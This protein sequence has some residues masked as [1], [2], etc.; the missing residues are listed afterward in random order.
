MRERE[1]AG[2][3]RDKHPDGMQ[4]LLLHYGPLIRYI[5]APIV[6]DAHDRED[7]FSEVTLRIW[8]KADR[9]AP[10]RGSWK[11]WLT[12]VTRNTAYN[13]ARQTARRGEGELPEHAPS[14]APDPEEALLWAE[15][16]RALQRALAQ[17]STA[18]QALFYRKYYYLQP[19]SQIASELGTTEDLPA[20]HE[21]VVAG[22]TPD[23]RALRRVVCVRR[24]GSCAACRDCAGD[25]VQLAR[26]CR[27][28]A[29]TRGVPLPLARAGRRATEGRAPV[30]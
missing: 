21:T 4:Q 25:G 27:R 20:P 19:T 11:A 30:R 10:Q 18:E 2:L 6:P 26:L 7:C 15:R 29:R 24:C 14:P 13:F 9:F 17:L 23:H 16:R 1:I 5:I 8:E 28:G 22:V 12:A 3:L